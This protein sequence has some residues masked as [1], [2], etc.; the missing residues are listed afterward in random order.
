MQASKWALRRNVHPGGCLERP[1]S[2]KG[3]SGDKPKIPRAFTSRERNFNPECKAYEAFSKQFYEGEGSHRDSLTLTWHTGYGSVGHLELMGDRSD[4]E[5]QRLVGLLKE[6]FAPGE[7]QQLDLDPSFRTCNDENVWLRKFELDRQPKVSTGL[8]GY[9][10]AE[11]GGQ[12]GVD[13]VCAVLMAEQ[14][15]LRQQVGKPLFKG[16]IADEDGI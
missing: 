4:L 2:W 8:N 10:T 12:G 1:A 5:N 6:A 11:I 14:L 13:S 9:L 3:L 15:A 16:D 7:L